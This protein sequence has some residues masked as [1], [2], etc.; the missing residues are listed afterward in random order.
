MKK[1][2][3][4]PTIFIILIIFTPPLLQVVHPD[5]IGERGLGG[6]V[7]AQCSAWTQKA[8][9]GGTGR[10]DPIGFNIGNKGY[11]GVGYDGIHR[12]DFWEYDPANNTWS[13]KANFGGAGRTEAVGF[14][15][16]SKGYIGTGHLGG[17][18]ATRD[19]WE[20]DLSSNTW[21]QKANFGGTARR[22]AVGFSIGGKGYIGTGYDPATVLYKDFWE[23]DTSANI[24][25]QKADFGGSARN[26]AACF[27]IGGK[28][29]VGTGSPDG[30]IT[31]RDFW[32]YDTTGNT[33][34]Q[35]T[36]FGGAG[37]WGAV[38][39]SIGS[40]GFL[41]TGYA[42]GI[43]RYKD[44]WEYDPNNNKWRPISDLPGTARQL[45]AGF[46]IGNKGY[47]GTGEPGM[48][49][50]F[51]EYD[52]AGETKANICLITVD[53][54]STK[55][56]IVWENPVSNVIDSFRIYRNIV[57]TFTHIGS[58]AYNALS[59]YT[60]ITPGIN[61]N[62]TSY[63]YKIAVLDTCGNESVLSIFHKT[64]HLQISLGIPPAINLS[65][66]DYIGFT[67]WYYRILR[68]S[69]GTG[70][71]ELK[72]SVDNGTLSWTDPSPPQTPNLSYLVEAVLPAG[73]A[74]TLMKKG[75]NYNTSKSNKAN[76]QTTGIPNPD[77][78][79]DLKIYPNPFTSKTQISYSLTQRA[80]ISLE[81]YNILGKKVQTLV[82][83][84]QNSG[85]YQYD[86]STKDLSYKEGV[87]VLKLIINEKV[88]NK[89]LVEIK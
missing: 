64:I 23:Y 79:R 88:R 62:N 30:S 63:K 34:A 1:L 72:D 20:Y 54:T 85:A 27:V 32:E 59:D 36:D 25:T 12:I 31:K 86:F 4:L 56:V 48:Y 61:P 68:D 67:S 29:Y 49:K 6:E 80:H 55:N 33:W 44:F 60:D 65:W 83:E 40:K 58:V 42:P 46:S 26:E 17:S 45:S 50:D 8:D 21:T 82:N 43:G 10:W 22:G 35:I 89:L 39:F 38:G 2:N 9:F 78:Y 81:V 52:P 75:K 5:L 13:Q 41:G 87:F 3:F 37:R 14:S 69:T 51:W 71:W 57:G 77:N 16:G 76:K 18:I 70:N 47:I 19:F 73:C 66:D 11:I 7:F 15:I 84:V 53:S 74:A 24:W 28:G